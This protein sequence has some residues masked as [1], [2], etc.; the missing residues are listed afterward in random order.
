M[1]MLQKEKVQHEQICEM[2]LSFFW[3]NENVFSFKPL[4]SLDPK[5]IIDHL[6]AGCIS[7]L[8]L[9]IYFH[10]DSCTFSPL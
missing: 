7:V 6:C 5:I 9:F 2:L 10:S 4:L 8:I 1:K 3:A